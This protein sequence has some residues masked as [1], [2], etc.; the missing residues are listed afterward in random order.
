M[1]P[2]PSGLL[3]KRS[4]SLIV[5]TPV[6]VIGVASP[7]NRLPAPFLITWPLPVIA[8]FMNPNDDVCV[9]VSVPA[10]IAMVLDESKTVPIVSVRPFR[11][12]VVVGTAT[13][14]AS[15]G[16]APLAPTRKTP[17]STLP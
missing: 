3:M 6:N 10:P 4:P 12:K 11:S 17:P 2:T 1:V 5:V 14:L 8:P 7:T 9:M 13:R 16:I 15:S